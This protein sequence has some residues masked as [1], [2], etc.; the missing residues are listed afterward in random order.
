MPALRRPLQPIN[1]NGESKRELTPYKRAQIEGARIVGASWGQ[2]QYTFE[3]A[4]STARNTLT[5][6]P[7]RQNA[8]S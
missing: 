7:L 5:Q 8:T 4:K 6:A 2:I 1:P 3:V